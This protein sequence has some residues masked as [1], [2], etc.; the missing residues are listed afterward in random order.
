MKKR[1]LLPLLLA[2]VAMMFA[3]AGCGGSDTAEES[4]ADTLVLGSLTDFKTGS[5]YEGA[6]LI[7]EK[8]LNLDEDMSIVPGIIESWDINDEHVTLGVSKV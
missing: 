3:L 7:F 5:A 6:S 2:A 1:L 4:D 8:L